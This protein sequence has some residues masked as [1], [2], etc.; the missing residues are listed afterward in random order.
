MGAGGSRS[1]KSRQK[2][3]SKDES[4]KSIRGKNGSL[5]Q[6]GSGLDKRVNSAKWKIM[7]SSDEARIKYD[8]DGTL[9][10]NSDP[11]HLELRY[12]YIH[13]FMYICIYIYTYI[14]IHIYKYIYIYSNI[15]I[16]MY[17]HICIYIYI[18]TY[19]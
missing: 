7:P 14:Y 6:G 1:Q 18:Y 13:I 19:I 17:I 16:Y 2:S 4:S 12:I 3:I 15:Y 10:K 9:F 11:E 8:A 5:K